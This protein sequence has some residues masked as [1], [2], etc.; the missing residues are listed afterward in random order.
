MTDTNMLEQSRLR[1][2]IAG[3]ALA[4]MAVLVYG[5]ALHSTGFVWD[6]YS[7]F[8]GNWLSAPGSL[9]RIWF[10]PWELRG[11]EHYWPVT[12]TLF[13]LQNLVWGS[14]N[15]VGWHLVNVLFHAANTVL[16]WQLLKRL[17]IPG[18]WLAAALFAVHPVHVD[19]VAWIIELKDVLSAFFCLVAAMLYLH[20]SDFGRRLACG[21]ALAAFALALMSKSVAVTLPAALVILEWWRNP[22]LTRRHWLIVAPFVVLAVIFVAFDLT[23]VG[24]AANPVPVISWPERAYVA[25]MAVF[26]YAKTIVWPVNLCPVELRWFDLP[27]TGV[28]PFVPV[29]LLA[30]LLAVLAKRIRRGKGPLALALLYIALL[31]P[32]LGIIPFSYMRYSYV[33]NRF[34]YLACLVPLAGIPG[35]LAQFNQRPGQTFRKLV[36][37]MAAVVICVLGYMT[38]NYSRIYRD[39]ETWATYTLEHNPAAAPA[40]EILA[41]TFAARGEFEKSAAHAATAVTIDPD[42]TSARYMW[43]LGLFKTNKHREAIEQLNTALAQNPKHLNSLILRAGIQ[44]SKGDRSAA[45]AD[46][47]TVLKLDATNSRALSGLKDLQTSP[48][49]TNP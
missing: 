7:L 26:H 1:P 14:A 6:D 11:E 30:A 41:A 21:G 5:P 23:M 4:A 19:S 27:S 16:A 29:A 35:M 12:Y 13:Y 22:K 44:A 15:P 8:A 33:A 47:Q 43:A 38:W 40:C 34:Q 24:R 17:R 20:Y 46:Y 18:A 2:A 10:R 39:N 45:E 32:T 48:T 31:S 28:M 3:L 49:H 37:V 9:T 25:G 42:N 36:M